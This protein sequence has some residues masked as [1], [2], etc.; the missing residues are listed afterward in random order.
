[1]NKLLKY[2]DAN[3]LFKPALRLE[4][5]I[6]LVNTKGKTDIASF[7][8]RHNVLN[9]KVISRPDMCRAVK[10]TRSILQAANVQDSKLAIDGVALLPNDYLV[11]SLQIQVSDPRRKKTFIVN[12]VDFKKEYLQFESIK[13][14]NGGA[15]ISYENVRAFCCNLYGVCI[16]TA[17][18]IQDAIEQLRN[19]PSESTIDEG[20]LNALEEYL[21]PFNTYGNTI[22]LLHH[23][24]TL[25]GC[26]SSVHSD[27]RLYTKQCIELWND[28]L[29]N[30]SH[31]MA[32]QLTETMQ[33]LNASY[34]GAGIRRLV[35][36]NKTRV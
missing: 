2:L 10:I 16:R 1:M 31:I 24:N 21:Q 8:S 22:E 13:K 7:V 12:P 29:V 17:E 11:Q 14:Q 30:T 36:K 9:G 26:I 15:Y 27:G 6:D 3:D 32:N 23:L 18:D 20:K 28:L 33:A 35:R 4:T 25:R 5:E 19:I 34:A